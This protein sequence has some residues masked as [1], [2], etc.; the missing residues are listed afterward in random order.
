MAAQP[1]WLEPFVDTRTGRLTTPWLRYLQQLLSGAAGGDVVGPASSTDNAVARFDGATGKLLQNSGITIADGATGTLAG[2]NSGDVTLAGTPDY[3]TISNQVITRGLIDLTTDVSGV[4]PA[5][6]GGVVLVDTTTLTNA[7]ILAL[8]TTPITL[9]SAPSA[10]TRIKPIGATFR[11]DFAAGYT[12]IDATYAACAIYW[13]GDFSQWAQTGIVD[14]AAATLTRFTDIFGA[15][16]EET[17]DTIPYHDSFTNGWVI[18]NAVG[19]SL[20]DGIALAVAMDNN[21]SGN[22]TGGNAANTLTITVYYVVQAV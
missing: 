20:S 13:L 21:G 22:L 9:I 14:D 10:G 17:I 15:L 16:G 12:N 18:P 11:S 3:L 7:Q 5:A 4:L 19:V 1:N 8:P 6:N 2:S